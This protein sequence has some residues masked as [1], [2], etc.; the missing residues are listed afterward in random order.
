MSVD[1]LFN[2]GVYMAFVGGITG[3]NIGGCRL[4]WSTR[5]DVGGR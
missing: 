1:V 3:I 5:I 2:A 4:G